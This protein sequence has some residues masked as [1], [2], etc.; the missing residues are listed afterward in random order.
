MVMQFKIIKGVAGDK[1]EE[2]KQVKPLSRTKHA[3]TSPGGSF[4][5]RIWID[6]IGVP[7]GV[8]DEFK[9]RDQIAAGF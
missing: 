1:K 5:N 3:V 6:S 7:R 4:D 9:G 2:L 8:P